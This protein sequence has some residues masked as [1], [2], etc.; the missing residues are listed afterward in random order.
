VKDF[1]DMTL[2]GKIPEQILLELR[3]KMGSLEAALLAKDP[4]MPNH[5]R[6]SHR[7]LITYP[8]SVHLL[9]DNEIHCLIEAAEEH[10]KVKI[11]QEAAK[12]KGTRKKEINAALDL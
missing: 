1:Q 2:K 12:G 6:E 3:L 5:L 11:V 7:L 10:T 8:E 4:E 9:D